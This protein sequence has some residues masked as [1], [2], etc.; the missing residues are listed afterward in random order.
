MQL[1]IGMFSNIFNGSTDSPNTH[2]ASHGWMPM[3]VNAF[4]KITSNSWNGVA[5][6]CSRLENSFS[7][8]AGRTFFRINPT[9]PL[10][11]GSAR[12]SPRT[13]QRASPFLWTTQVSHEE[14]VVLAPENGAKTQTKRT[15]V[16]VPKAR[17]QTRS[18]AVVFDRRVFPHD[19]KTINGVERPRSAVR[20]ADPDGTLRKPIAESASDAPVARRPKPNA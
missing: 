16:G 6:R 20:T 19:G 17:A 3:D 10:R 1:I 9:F 14:P 8:G 2:V 5:W 7:F 12:L 11:G 13:R 4:I 18:S 15:T